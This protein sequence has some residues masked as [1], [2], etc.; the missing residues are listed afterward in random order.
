MYPYLYNLR[1][2]YHEK[3]PNIFPVGFC[4]ANNITLTPP[5]GY[6]INNF[7]WESYLR[8][9]NAIPAGEHLF[10]RDVP[11]HGFEVII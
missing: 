4:A 9:T 6:N 3:S 7:T 5:N 1:F 11:N 2:C 8:E 10:H